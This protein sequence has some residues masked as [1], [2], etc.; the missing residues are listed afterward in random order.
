[1]TENYLF[2]VHDIANLLGINEAT[3]T[4]LIRLGKI[5]ASMIN[6]R[7]GYRITNADF[8]DYC[9][10]RGLNFEDLIKKYEFATVED[11]EVIKP[12]T[13]QDSNSIF[14]YPANPFHP[15]FNSL[16]K[17]VDEQNI[18]ANIHNAL[19]E[20]EDIAKEFCI[21]VN[22]FYL[23]LKRYEYVYST[24]PNVYFPAPAL[25]NFHLVKAKMY[26]TSDFLWTYIG[27]RFIEDQ[28]VFIIGL[29]IGDKV[30]N[31]IIVESILS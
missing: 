11:N 13:P 28:L 22:M 1:M 24:K 30:K 26:Q 7:I 27:K 9:K 31:K 15:E 6:R 17:P 4:G 18:I 25:I 14:E 23:L 10:T 20:T 16:Y 8:R 3:V 29:S 12:K 5:K 2:T 19:F 21:D